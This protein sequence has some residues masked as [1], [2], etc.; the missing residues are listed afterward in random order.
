MSAWKADAL[1]LGDARVVYQV[2][3]RKNLKF[4]QVLVDIL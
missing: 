4:A 3:S 1:P 2:M